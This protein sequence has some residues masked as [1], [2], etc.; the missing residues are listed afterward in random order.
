MGD[1][2]TGGPVLRARLPPPRSSSASRTAGASRIVLLVVLGFEGM[3]RLCRRLDASAVGA[4]F[5]A[6]VYGTCDRFV[7]FIHDGWVNF[8]GFELIP[9]V[10]YFLVEGTLGPADPTLSAA[11]RVRARPS[12]APPRWFLR[13]VDRPL[14]GHVPDA[15]RDAFGSATSPPRSASM[16]S[17]GAGPT[18]GRHATGSRREPVAARPPGAVAGALARGGD[19]RARGARALRREDA[20]DALVPP[21]VPL[22]AFTPVETHTAAEMFTG[23]WGRYSAVLALALVGVVTA[24]LAAGI[25]FGGAILFFALAM[26]DFGDGSPFH[27]LKSLPDLR[28]AP[29]PRSLHGRCAPVLVRRR[30]A[31]R[32]RAWRTPCLSR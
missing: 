31:R 18:T 28:T 2:R 25:F 4:T 1:R 20:P 24:D 12:R 8:M 6:V 5:A 23:Y 15:L 21:A 27:I 16:A 19:D 7:S 30:G 9:F 3:Y 26:G 32:S 29:L 10:L 14:G 22:R 13:R 11:S 17:S